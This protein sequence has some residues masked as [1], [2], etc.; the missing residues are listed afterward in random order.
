MKAWLTSFYVAIFA[1]VVLGLGAQASADDGDPDA[2]ALANSQDVRALMTRQPNVDVRVV[3][4]HPAP[5]QSTCRWAAI[6]RGLT[7]DA[8]PESALSLAFYHFA[9][10][11]R[12]VDQIRRLAKSPR[13]PS[14]VRTEDSGDEVLRT[15]TTTVVTR[16]AS[17][18]VVVDAGDT[19]TIAREQ[20]G[21]TY[22]LEAL[23]L[24]A[25][26]AK[27]AGPADP[28]AVAP[29]CQLATPA[30]VLALLT[31]SPSQLEADS[32][33]GSGLRCYFSV[34][35]ASRSPAIAVSNDGTA[36]VRFEDLGT[37]TAALERLHFD[38]PFYKPSTLVSTDE[39]TDRVV[40]TPDHPEEVEAVHG[41]YL[42]TLNLTG[43]TPA[44]SASATWTY[45]VQR[46]ALEI[47]GAKVL[48]NANLPPDPVTPGPAPPPAAFSWRMSDHTAP[49][50][51]WFADP[52]VHALVFM[53]RYRFLMM[54]A[55][56]LCGVLVA[57]LGSGKQR[58]SRRWI[59]M[60]ALIGVAV[61]NLTLGTW[62]SGS[63]IYAVGDEG[64][65]T[66]TGSRGTG[67]V[68]NSHR[69]RAYD[70]LIRTV[71]GQTVETGFEDD[72]FNVYPHHNATTYPGKG[73]EFNVRYLKGFPADFVILGEDDSPWAKGLRCDR[74]ASRRSQAESKARFAPDVASYRDA[75]QAAKEAEAQASCDPAQ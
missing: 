72:D 33:D 1:T 73:D 67:T 57:V 7:D 47:A 15:D 51:S 48:P 29:V 71:D 19:Q 31:L 50:W 36:Q 69:V 44:A 59:L 49:A 20:A 60:P 30:H 65:A 58:P 18:I 39:A 32:S 12:A 13:A 28:R 3:P 27:V 45:R 43:V 4:G 61:L 70:V 75:A 22:R 34:K 40:A 62:V 55:L 68:Y 25:A 2:C 66:I 24:T 41:P 52:F 42:V 14:L 17:D 21:W 26:G 63:V 74:L 5:G 64:K 23:A 16:H 10:V 38:H 56:I 54:P 6:Q 11:E 35:D 9:N 53:A 37:N 46:T 8:P